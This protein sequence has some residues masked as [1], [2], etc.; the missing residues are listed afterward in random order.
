V[1]VLQDDPAAQLY[2]M[3]MWAHDKDEVFV[4]RIRRDENTTK[5]FEPL[6]SE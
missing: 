3:P 4:G 2:P 1:L 5:N 6:G